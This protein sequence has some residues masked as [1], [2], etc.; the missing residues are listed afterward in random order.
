LYFKK[1]LRENYPSRWVV[2]STIGTTFLTLI[3][4]WY[5]AKAF[6]PTFEILG[7]LG[8]DY[9]TFVVVGELLMA[10]PLIFLATGVSEFRGFMMN[11]TIEPLMVSQTPFH[12]TLLIATFG[13]AL[14]ALIQY[15]LMVV[16]AVSFFSLNLPLLNVL[17]TLIFQLLT[18]PLFIA[19]GLFAGGIY[20][21]FGRGA[22]LVSAV[23]SVINV[24]SGVYF[25]TS[26]FPPMLESA[27]RIASPYH[28]LIEE[29]RKLLAFGWQASTSQA[30]LSF[31]VLGAILLPTSLWFIKIAITKHQRRGIS[32]FYLS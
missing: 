5:T 30:A 24:F 2:F 12:K 28:L 16:L 25:P 1:T 4:Y 8:N 7:E 32:L 18:Y 21:F 15:A 31:L 11:G 3:I 29:S 27:L 6:R 10:V 23:G 17:P 14:V 13:H 9:F 22:G 19:F 26:V 20:L